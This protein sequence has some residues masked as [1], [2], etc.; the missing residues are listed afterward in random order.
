MSKN[1]VHVAIAI[2]LHKSKILVGWRQASQHQ[3]NKHEFPGGKVEQDETPEQA[4]RREIYEEVGI[5]IK[6]WHVF[7]VIRHEYDDVIVHLHLFHAYVPDEL[8][9]LIHQPWTWY[10]RDQLAELNFPK[11][12][13]QIVQRLMWPHL[14][15]VSS[16]LMALPES[17]C[18]LYWRMQP[19]DVDQIE[20][21]LFTLSDEQLQKLMLN[22]DIWQKLATVLQTKIQTI[23]LKQSQL[24]S[25]K[26]GELPVGKRL[27]AACHDAVSLQ[28]AHVI[29]CDAV[30]LSP[31]NATETHP[32]ARILGWA[33]FSELAKESHLPVFALGGVAPEDIE[34][35][36]KHHA[37]GLAGI[38]QFESLN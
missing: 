20:A 36:Q 8:L 30:L 10:S 16:E 29:G 31:V 1:T 5:G 24:L 6:N 4:C 32:D 35:A 19:Q 28:H 9:D 27:I 26:K 33:G 13:T 17:D 12:N 25:L 37:Y 7:D 3:G 22:F 18:L 23:H 21:Q 34:Q 2:L 14:I 38:R 11:A 15:K